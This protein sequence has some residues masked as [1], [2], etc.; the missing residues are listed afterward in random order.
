MEEKVKARTVIDARIRHGKPII[1]GTRI[2]VE[3]VLGAL[4]GGMNYDEI[5]KEYGIKK[6]DILAV[7]EYVA[8]FVRG[9]EV[10]YKKA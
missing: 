10:G 1:K 5:E 3:E 2:T 9:E 8:S 6:E 4:I 7:L